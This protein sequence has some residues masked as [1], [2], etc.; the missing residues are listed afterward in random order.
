MD[1]VDKLGGAVLYDGDV[2]D[3]RPED[4]KGVIVALKA[5]G[6]AKGDTSGFVIQR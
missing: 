3:Y 2:T 1:A 5:K 4:P 6:D